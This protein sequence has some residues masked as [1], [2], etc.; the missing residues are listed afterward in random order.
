MAI[1]RIVAAGPA[2]VELVSENPRRMSFIVQ[3]VSD[4]EIICL[5]NK[6]GKE[7]EGIYL[8]PHSW[9]QLFED[10][11]ADK[12]WYVFSITGG[13]TNI[14]LIELFPKAKKTPWMW[15]W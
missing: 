9:L 2:G 1:I 13:A 6:P 5:Y 10:D 15:P 11:D 14:H 8:Y 4:S 7:Y 12:Q 3:N